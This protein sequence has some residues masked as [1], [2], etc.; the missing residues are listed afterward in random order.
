MARPI[1]KGSISFGLVNIPVSLYSGEQ[2]QDMS[3]NLLDRRD[4][5]HIK[6]KRVNEVTGKEV[7]WENIVKG[8]EIEK[9][10]YVLLEDKD[11]ESVAME[12]TKMVEITDFVDLEEIDPQYFD[13]PYYLVPEK[14]GEKGYVLL[15]DTLK[16]QK[17]AG[18]AKVVIRSRENL[19]CV[20]P[21][22]DTLQMIVLRFHEEV[23]EPDDIGFPSKNL[24]KHKVSE[25]ELAIAGQLV[26]AMSSDWDPEQYKDEYRAALKDYVQKKY[27]E[28]DDFKP[29][30]I[31]PEKPS[32][33]TDIM[34]LLQQ[35]LAAR[36]G[37]GNGHGKT[38]KK[39][40]AK[41]KKTA[42]NAS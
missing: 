5:A 20:I 25:R 2:R 3:F 37:N 36:G 10:H 18:I 26:E 22:G 42:K 8:Y 4:Q 6:Y 16:Q 7:P 39:P 38:E 28:G 23:K 9:D 40:A 35:S 19:A 30:T 27:E 33:A 14:A 34:E 31:A 15:R 17:R 11:F 1:W 21:Y 32:K 24:D 12:N 29:P 41:E 13:K